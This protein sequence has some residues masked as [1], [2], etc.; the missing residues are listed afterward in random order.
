M[1]LDFISLSVFPRSTTKL[2]HSVS[3]GFFFGILHEH[4][5]K[6]VKMKVDR[7]CKLLLLGLLQLFSCKNEARVL[8]LQKAA[9]SCSVGLPLTKLNTCF[10]D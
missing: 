9:S 2:T 5:K 6:V 1:L 3:I 4:V 7:N 10:I 8:L